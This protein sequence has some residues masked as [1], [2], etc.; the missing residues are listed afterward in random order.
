MA[1]Q[2][3]HGLPGNTKSAALGSVRTAPGSAVVGGVGRPGAAW[4]TPN[5]AHA[6]SGKARLMVR[7][8]IVGFGMVSA[9]TI[10]RAAMADVERID[11]GGR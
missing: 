1:V 7:W 2:C 3:C 6:A 9:I 5:N 8:V 4:P 10:A 11:P